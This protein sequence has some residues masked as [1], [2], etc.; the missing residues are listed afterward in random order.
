MSLASIVSCAT[1]N[2]AICAT[3]TFG[4]NYGYSGDFDASLKA[5]VTAGVSA[6]AF[7]AVAN[8]IEGAGWA[9][10]GA[11]AGAWY[12]RGANVALNAK[13]FTAL[14]GAQTT[15]GGISAVLQGG[16]FGHGFASAGFSKAAGA[17][18]GDWNSGLSVGDLDIGQTVVAAVVGGTASEISGGKFANGAVTGALLNM[19][20]QQGINRASKGKV[21]SEELGQAEF[22][23]SSTTEDGVTTYSKVNN[24]TGKIVASLTLDEGGHISVRCI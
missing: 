7:G 11:D 3:G 8:G 15:L 10:A 6:A 19:Y 5:G 1:G 4:A 12:N 9:K 14:I 17:S 13:G 23:I 2:I 18:I 21:A 16:K 22:S 24:E 20:N